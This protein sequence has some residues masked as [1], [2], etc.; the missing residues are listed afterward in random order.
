MEKNFETYGID[1]ESPDLYQ[2]TPQ[3]ITLYLKA[4]YQESELDPQA[5]CKECLQVQ[6]FPGGFP[7]PKI[8][9]D[10]G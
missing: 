6:G 5:T 3:N 1:R 7:S 9:A 2:T 10:K 8:P 4:I